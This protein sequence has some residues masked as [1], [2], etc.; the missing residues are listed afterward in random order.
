MGYKR[1]KNLRFYDAI[2]LKHGKKVIH[3]RPPPSLQQGRN[4]LVYEYFEFNRSL[5]ISNLELSDE[6]I[7]KHLQKLNEFKPY[8][9]LGTPSTLYLISQYIL[10]NNIDVHPVKVTLCTSET[11][12][13]YQRK[14]IE[15]AFGCDIFEEW[16]QGEMVG[17]AFECKNHGFHLSEEIGLVEFLKDNEDVAAGE[18]GEIVGT[19]LINKSMPL[20]RYYVGDA[21]IPSD[22]VCSCGRGLS[23]VDRILGKTRENIVTKSGKKIP[24]ESFTWIVMEQDWIKESQI[25]QP[26]VNKCIIKIVPL[27]NV[28]KEKENNLIRQVKNIIGKKEEMEI[29]VEYVEKIYPTQAG[30]RPFVI[31]KVKQ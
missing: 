14:V 31:S 5:Y 20:I 7:E 10:R 16:G 19:T 11:L 27:G 29:S 6:I 23:L 15:D 26:S 12:Y 21:G 28:E 22:D 3:F 13:P 4:N 1:A 2:N 25:F 18:E 30:K 24:G 8:A 17:S 9:I